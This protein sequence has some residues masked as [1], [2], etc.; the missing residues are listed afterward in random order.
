MVMEREMI[1]SLREDT[2]QPCRVFSFSMFAY[3]WTKALGMTTT[4]RYRHG[5][6]DAPVVADGW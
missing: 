4:H 2:Q 5:P 6:D 3:V 1:F